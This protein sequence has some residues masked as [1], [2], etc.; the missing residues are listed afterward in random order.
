MTSGSY[1]QPVGPFRHDYDLSHCNTLKLVSRALGGMEITGLA[2]IMALDE[3]SARQMLPLYIL[4]GGSNVVLAEEIDGLIGLMRIRERTLRETGTHFIVT[5]GAGEV[6]DDVVRW[7]VDLGIGGLENLAGIPGTAGAAPVQNIGAYGVQLSDVFHE[8]TAFDR[9]ARQLIRFDRQACAFS[10]RHSVFKHE[11]GR[12]IIVSVSLALPRDW[13][14]NCQYPG[15]EQLGSAPSPAAVFAA[16]TALRG[17]K[18]PDW[19][20]LGNAG[21]FFHN[22]IVAPAIAEAIAGGPRYPQDDGRI[23][24]SAGWLIEQCGLKGTRLGPVGMY[25]GHALVLV[26]HGLSTTH[27][28]VEALARLVTER[29]RQRFGVTLQQEPVVFGNPMMPKRA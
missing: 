2:D 25:E 3:L 7:T 17:S 8:L 27:R 12:Y 13:T 20:R 24:L 6:W 22:P 21:S 11:P 16:V 5:A 19:R 1:A 15:L 23:K 29:V 18:L 26:N 9:K 10:Y 14:A 4:G 28:D